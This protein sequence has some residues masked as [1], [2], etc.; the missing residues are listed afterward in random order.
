MHNIGAKHI[1]QWKKKNVYYIQRH[2][3]V[4]AI[5]IH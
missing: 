1:N 4:S 5:F 2:I 3:Y